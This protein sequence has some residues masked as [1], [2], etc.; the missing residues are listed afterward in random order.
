MS[1]LSERELGAAGFRA[2]GEDVRI[3]HKASIHGAERI[4]IGDHVRID[5]FCIL[6]AGEG[7]IAIGSFIHIAAYCSLIGVGEIR[8][9]DFAGLSSRVS[10]YSSSDDYSGRTM[11]NPMVPPEYKAVDERP[12]RIGRHAIIGCG[13]VILPGVSI[14]EG[15]AIGALSVVRKDCADFTIHVGNPA[16][17]VGQRDRGLLEHEQAFRNASDPTNGAQ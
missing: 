16:R 8:L 10:L 6:S 2:I 13:S 15:A 5:D 12:V 9:E 11:T 14:G 3:S 17:L 1:F 7:G 4:T